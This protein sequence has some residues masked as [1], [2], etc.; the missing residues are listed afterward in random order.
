MQIKVTARHG[1]LSDESQQLLVSK[2]EKLLRFF[3]RL[4]SIEVVVDLKNHN[5]PN[6]ELLV[7]A[8]HKHDFVSH[9]ESQNLLTAIEGA[10]HKMEQQLKKYK[11]KTI[12]QHRNPDS[13]ARGPR[14][15]GAVADAGSEDAG[16]E[17]LEQ[18]VGVEDE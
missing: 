16:S 8:E 12:D 4:T 1:H 3:E 17:D 10:V 18:N 7:S 9:Q 5:K 2:S 15:L 11:E 14:D 13:A 6:V